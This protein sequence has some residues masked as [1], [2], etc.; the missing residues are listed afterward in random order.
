MIL[1][2]RIAAV[3]I[4][5]VT[6]LARLFEAGFM[7]ELEGH[8]LRVNTFSR[9]WHRQ[10]VIRAN[11]DRCCPAFIYPIIGVYDLDAHSFV[12]ETQLGQRV[13]SKGAV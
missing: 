4:L 1:S 12:P 9:R 13:D 2:H 10:M 5:V 11:C 8:E 7:F 3:S 6:L